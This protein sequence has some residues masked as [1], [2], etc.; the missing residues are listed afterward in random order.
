VQKQEQIRNTLL[1]GRFDVCVT[2]FETAIMEKAALRKFSWWYVLNL[3]LLV[4]VPTCVDQLCDHG[5]GAS[6]Q[7]RRF[8][9]VA[10]GPHGDLAIPS[11]HHGNTSPGLSACGTTEGV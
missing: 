9:S 7:E 1:A 11:A 10:A 6:H 4:F 3:L 8:G 5:R 2:T